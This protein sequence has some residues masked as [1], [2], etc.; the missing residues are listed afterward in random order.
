VDNQYAA[1]PPDRS[2][3]F[4]SLA[5]PEPAWVEIGDLEIM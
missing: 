4:G 2:P 3:S 1:L 5:N